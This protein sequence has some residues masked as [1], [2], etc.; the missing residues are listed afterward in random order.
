MMNRKMIVSVVALCALLAIPFT[1][2]T[3]NAAM[4]AGNRNPSALP[5]AA[6]TDETETSDDRLASVAKQV[7]GFGGMFFDQDGTLQVYMSGQKGPVDQALMTFLD[8]VITR[9]VGRGERL[10]TKGV[11]VRE[12]Q[13]NFLELYSWQRLCCTNLSEELRMR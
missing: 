6:Q 4:S 2:N 5:G 10:S 1:S 12:G 3:G 9:E 11:E 8:D 7:P 13:Y